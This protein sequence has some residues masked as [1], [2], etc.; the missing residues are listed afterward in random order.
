MVLGLQG[1]GRVGRRRFFS[2]Y[3]PPQG[4]LES[5]NG[6]A[7]LA[8]VMES[9]E[10]DRLRLER[11]DHAEHRAG[12]VALNADPEVS[13]YVGG[14]EPF[15]E[16]ESDELSLRIPLHWETHGFGLWAALRK[17]SGAMIGFV[18]LCHPVWWP[19]MVGRVEVGWRLA[20]DAWG[21]GYATEG[22]REALRAGFGR[23]ALAE[24][25]AFVHPANE[26][27]LAV[28]RRLGMVEEAEVPHPTR[29]HTLKIL[30]V[31]CS[32]S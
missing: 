32:T 23:L 24:I 9:A 14:G 27:S 26:R 6:C 30:R 31:E 8:A 19:A 13:K 4:R 18:G 16:R 17:D 28:T 12:L 5:F 15:S 2:E 22:A 10:T 1:P 29:D 11:W 7:S 20:R 21:A 25:V 3:G